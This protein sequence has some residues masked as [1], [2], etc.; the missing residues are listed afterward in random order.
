M[1]ENIYYSL[2]FSIPVI[3]I[4]AVQLFNLKYKKRF[5]SVLTLICIII[6]VVAL[7]F[8]YLILYFIGYVFSFTADVT[9]E[10]V[11]KLFFNDNNAEFEMTGRFP[12]LI[13]IFYIVLIIYFSL[14]IVI[15]I[16]NM[17]RIKNY[18]IITSLILTL[19][20]YFFILYLIFF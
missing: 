19:I 4:S 5:L 16:I 3:L 12:K 13:N 7:I 18:L 10:T 14:L 15:N 9:K 20:P 11:E 17:I 6:I 1:N 2:I 8:V